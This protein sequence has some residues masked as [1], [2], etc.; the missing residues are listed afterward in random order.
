MADNLSKNSK[1][2]NNPWKSATGWFIEKLVKA[3]KSLYNLLKKANNYD[4]P[5]YE[6][7]TRWKLGNST[8]GYIW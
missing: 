4:I 1:K 2:T 6:L 7:K 5:N 8:A 3:E